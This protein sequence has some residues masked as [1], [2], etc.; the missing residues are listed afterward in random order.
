MFEYNVITA[1]QTSHLKKIA[2]RTL[3]P[4]RGPTTIAGK[5]GRDCFL[6]YLSEYSK[7]DSINKSVSIFLSLHL[8][9]ILA[10]T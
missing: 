7:Q 5:I 6:T 9:S 1:L 10:K 4:I 2:L 8:F 3:S